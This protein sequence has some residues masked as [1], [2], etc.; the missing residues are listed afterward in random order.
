MI[1]KPGDIVLTRG[2]SIIAQAILLGETEPGEGKTLCNHSGVI[3]CGGPVNKASIIECLARGTVERPLAA[4]KAF[5]ADYAV[6]YRL[7]TLSES[8][9][10]AIVA[11]ARKM[12]GRRY[13]WLW[14]LAHA[15]DWII[16][17]RW[18]FRGKVP[19]GYT[20]PVCS[21]LVALLYDAALGYRFRLDVPPRA[22]QP[23]DIWDH[24]TTRVPPWEP[25]G[26]V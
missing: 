20:N 3:S 1:T 19:T 14:I 2:N 11:E 10:S 17:S 6:V 15:A 5:D 7:T 8:Q 26:V 25:V 24:V 12:V 21:G 13:G 9:A 4:Y 23:D 16:G 18:F 22:I